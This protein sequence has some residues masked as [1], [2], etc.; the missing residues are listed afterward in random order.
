MKL[1]KTRRLNRAFSLIELLV[2]IAII[3]LVVGI[4]IAALSHARRSAR[5]AATS[6][7]LRDLCSASTA[8]TT[9][10]HRSPGF[11][12]PT[13]M[14][15]GA[16]S[17]A[18]FTGMQNALLDLAGGITQAPTVPGQIITVGPGGT[19][20]VNLD[21][22]KIG[23][24]GTGKGYFTPS[25]NA[26]VAD[27]GLVGSAG[28]KQM[29]QI[30]DA[31]GNP[32]L[33]WIADERPSAA[34]ASVDSSTLAKFYWNANAGVLNATSIGKDGRNQRFTATGDTCSMLGGNNPNLAIT[35]A[36][37]LGN[38][39][40]PKPNNNAEPSAAR[41]SVVFHS[42]GSDGYFMGNSERGTKVYGTPG[43][44]IMSVPYRTGTNIDVMD[45]YN[46]VIQ[47]T[48]N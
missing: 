33:A 2:V 6:G 21:L 22:T 16:N 41:G 24:Q 8:F 42:A 18:G 36:G 9:D 20:T 25:K 46:D 11:F 43:T 31:F 15:S 35:M 13:V 10:S 23:A 3:A 37:L 4:L 45:Q 26:L 30:V 5:T 38:P 14:G 27:A 7:I 28:N 40:Y 32:I 1:A 34:F 48:G 29:P 44:P 12:S 17:T 47:A 39:A 19:N